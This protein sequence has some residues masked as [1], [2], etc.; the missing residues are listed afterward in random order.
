MKSNDSYL[1][2]VPDGVLK[3]LTIIAPYIFSFKPLV[4]GNYKSAIL[5]LFFGITSSLYWF[6]KILEKHEDIKH[7]KRFALAT[8]G[9]LMVSGIALLIAAMLTT[10]KNFLE[11]DDGFIKLIII[12]QILYGTQIIAIVYETV[13][14]GMSKKKA[15]EERI[16][17]TT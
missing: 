10:T 14:K 6:G 9:L 15:S 7:I 13:L 2:G 12:S 5:P 11:T 8:L 4:D 1:S 17:L 16:D 3:L